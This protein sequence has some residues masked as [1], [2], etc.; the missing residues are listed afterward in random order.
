M[1]GKFVLQ[2]QVIRSGSSNATPH[3]NQKRVKKDDIKIT[4]TISLLPPVSLCTPDELKPDVDVD[5]LTFQ[6]RTSAKVTK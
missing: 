4:Y 6:G 2:R 5:V 1:Y 3:I